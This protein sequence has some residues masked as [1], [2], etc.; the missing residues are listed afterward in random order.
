MEKTKLEKKELL[1]AVL[2]MGIAVS[3]ILGMTTVLAASCQIKIK[4][5][6]QKCSK[7]EI[8]N[9]TQAVKIKGLKQLLG[10]EIGYYTHTEVKHAFKKL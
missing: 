5:L 6:E 8:E 1:I 9:S 7:L 2:I 10:S 3:F 4:T